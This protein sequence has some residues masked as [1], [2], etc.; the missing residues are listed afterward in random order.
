MK[1][2][3]IRAR[4]ILSSGATP[5][6]E[7]EVELE[8]GSVGIA[9]VPFGASAGTYEAAVLLDHDEKRYFG[10]GMQKS[11][12]Y[13]NNDIKNQLI[14]HDAED[15]REIDNI[16]I[17]LDGTPNKSKLGGNAILSVSLAVA[18]ATA[19]EKN[20]PL[21]AY[22]RE[23][24]DLS[25]PEYVLP[26]PMMVMIEG[27]KHA[28]NST[29]LQEYLICSYGADSVKENVRMGIE[30]YHTT[31]KILKENK[32]NSNV[33]NE[34]AFAPAGISSNEQPLKFITDAITRTGYRV[35]D[36]VGLGIDAAASE[37]YEN[38][39]Y[40]LA[41][42]N[43]L[44]SSDDLMSY[45]LPWL[46]KYPIVTLEDMFH[47]DDWE[48]WQKFMPQIN[49]PHIG[50][51]LTVTNTSRL[52]K[53]IETKSISAILIKLNQIGSLSETV[54]CCMLARQNGLMTVTSHRGGGETND[55]AMIDLA[56]AVNSA[57]VKVGPSRGERVEKFNR[58]MR[59][60][61]ELEGRARVSGKDFKVIV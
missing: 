43:K 24:F 7:A 59:I 48:A 55:T 28:D 27:G 53:A 52:K 57:F 56:V 2:K 60:E 11:V 25:L 39:K 22:I 6:I 4:E 8:S 50:D 35:I 13:V 61:E 37:F 47:E 33:G 3:N 20:L 41:I 19:A 36:E 30:I 44:L 54:D 46:A 9:S 18:R 5:T 10:N 23:A 49:I 31:K 40:H 38:G 34:G 16:L 51:D 29:D 32:F 21:Y 14:G 1:I 26:N 12:G 45:Y 42:E 15:Q 58:L 17:A